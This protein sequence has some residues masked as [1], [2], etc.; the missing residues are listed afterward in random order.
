MW[1]GYRKAAGDGEA[2]GGR[3][4]LGAVSILVQKEAVTRPQR[5]LQPQKS[6]H[7]TE[8][9]PQERKRAIAAVVKREGARE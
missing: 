4:Q 3:Q 8:L 2:T 1:Q 7:W 9:G 6:G 5:E